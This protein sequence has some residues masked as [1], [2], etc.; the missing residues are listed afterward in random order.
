[1]LSSCGEG[2]IAATSSPHFGKVPKISGT[3][4]VPHCPRNNL[5]AAAPNVVHRASKKKGASCYV[6]TCILIFFSFFVLVAVS[7]HKS[8]GGVCTLCS[9]DVCA[10]VTLF[11]EQVS[12]ESSADSLGCH[13]VGI[14]FYC[15][16]RQSYHP[17]LTTN[18]L[19]PVITW[20]TRCSEH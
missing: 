4:W 7:G 17:Q 5:S 6:L 16:L 19:I 20:T 15:A 10:R 14:P 9:G 13:S 11:L 2:S 18:W 8:S 3:Y 12:G 1:M